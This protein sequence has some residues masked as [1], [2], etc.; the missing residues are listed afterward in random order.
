MSFMKS[1]P[2]QEDIEK[3]IKSHILNHHLANI[4]LYL[5]IIQKFQDNEYNNNH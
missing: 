2:L 4:Y 1:S 5:N 3:K